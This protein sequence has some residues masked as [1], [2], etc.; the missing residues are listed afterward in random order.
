MFLDE[1][2]VAILFR[3]I[4]FAVFMFF[5]VYLFKKYV[6]ENVKK[7]IADKQQE[8]IDLHNQADMLV[9]DI[10]IIERNAQQDVQM[11]HT[12][13]THV[14]NWRTQADRV[15]QENII[16][17]QEQ[18][19][20]LIAHVAI[21]TKY[22]ERRNAYEHILPVV[23]DQTQEKLEQKFEDE[24]LAKEFIAQLVTFMQKG[25]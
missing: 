15:A 21:Q 2:G 4:N 20:T 6:I 18:V 17:K 5:I 7:Q 25:G 12:L 9:E 23:I 3:L 13:K 14:V 22:L 8:K 11:C 19:E 16:K 24:V 10:R 1:S